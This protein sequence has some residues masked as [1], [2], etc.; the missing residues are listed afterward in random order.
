MAFTSSF[1]DAE[2]D[3][4]E[5]YDRVYSAED[6][7]EYFGLFIGNGVFPTPATQMQVTASTTPDMNVNVSSGFCWI[8]GYK[9]KNE[10]NYPL[11]IQAASGTQNRV[12]AVVVR[13]VKAD[14]K[15]EL[16]VKTGTA[17][18]SPV[19][20][21]LTRNGEVYEIELAT[22]TLAAGTTAI[23]QAMITDKRPDNTVCGFVTGVV[24]Q[25]DTTNLFA[26]YDDAFQTWF[27]NLKEQLSDN[28]VTNLQN[29][30][31]Q[32]DTKKV[33]VSD[34][35]TE[36]DI[37]NKDTTKWVSA[38]QLKESQL[39]V[40][41]IIELGETDSTDWLPLNNAIIALDNYPKFKEYAK[42]NLDFSAY[43]VPD[44]ELPTATKSLYRYS[45][46]LYGTHILGALI[47]GNKPS[48]HLCINLNG[49]P[50]KEI[51]IP[52]S[53]TINN[54][55]DISL[56]Y[57]NGTEVYLSGSTTWSSNSYVHHYFTIYYANSTALPVLLN[58]TSYNTN[59]SASNNP[60]YF[61]CGSNPFTDKVFYRSLASDALYHYLHGTVIKTENIQQVFGITSYSYG[62][63][64]NT[65]R[66]LRLQTQA[67]PSQ[68]KYY[69]CV[70]EVTIGPTSSS[71]PAIRYNTNSDY[72]KFCDLT[73]TTLT[74]WQFDMTGTALPSIV[75]SYNPVPS[76]FKALSLTGAFFI[77]NSILSVSANVEG[78]TVIQG[79]YLNIENPYL[80][81]TLVT[82]LKEYSLL[83]S[84]FI[85]SNK[86]W[87]VG[88]FVSLYAQNQSSYIKVT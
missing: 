63:S 80:T 27:D 83:G 6:F 10:D 75:A 3:V 87:K 51:N 1:F 42:Y 21:E 15:L 28:V 31:E 60:A 2:L 5:E 69:D 12:D 39:P 9:G 23:T 77:N 18:G 38:D 58:L 47:E 48:L 62:F 79:R 78:N 46:S 4:Y 30:I 19:A 74:I 14:R 64:D 35:A 40:G 52:I 34:K 82:P 61:I 65:Y 66:Y 84:Y 44:I 8:N 85:L 7:A 72:S 86:A 68:F 81:K 54:L 49:V 45:F 53:D 70:K 11:A 22:V 26:Q 13:W 57:T 41:S 24:Q 36:Q 73:S 16:A 50:Y 67:N 29:Q 55:Y 33:N 56:N 25:I 37:L 43:G 32:L 71:F 88:N 59:G 76:G 20:P 17:A